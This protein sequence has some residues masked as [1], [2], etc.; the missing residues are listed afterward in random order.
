MKYAGL[1]LAGAIAFTS[2]NT[3][4]AAPSTSSDFDKEA[5]L[6]S[7]MTVELARASTAC[8]FNR[9]RG[10]INAK[11]HEQPF[12]AAL[13]VLDRCSSG[14]KL[15][16]DLEKIPSAKRL[17]VVRRW[18]WVV[19]KSAVDSFHEGLAD[20]WPEDVPEVP[21][22]TELYSWPFVLDWAQNTRK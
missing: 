16:F 5:Y 4:L 13:F 6:R 2:A 1:I 12:N 10:L 9:T 11:Q 20:D 17:A 22:G 7:E 14:L 15:L 18:L 3:S 21:E 19:I 8:V